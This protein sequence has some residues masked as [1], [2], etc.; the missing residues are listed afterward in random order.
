V[1]IQCLVPDPAGD[2]RQN[3]A[4]TLVSLPDQQ[5]NLRSRTLRDLAGTTWSLDA[6][7]RLD[8]GEEKTI[9]RNGQDMALNKGTDTVELVDDEGRMVDT[10]TYGRVDRDEVVVT[11]R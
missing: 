7:R 6:L 3:E 4:V 10:V 1:W 9:Q 5:V 8:P 11:G 2:D